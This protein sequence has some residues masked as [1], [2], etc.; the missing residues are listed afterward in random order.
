[1]ILFQKIATNVLKPET[2]R[3]HP[4]NYGEKWMQLV[5][6]EKGGVNCLD[7]I[8]GLPVILTENIPQFKEK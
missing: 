8:A 3:M 2:M 5:W 1:M 6:K 4:L 7:C